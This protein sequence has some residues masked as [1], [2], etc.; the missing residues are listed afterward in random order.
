MI[1]DG[2]SIVDFTWGN[3]TIG[4]ES[5]LPQAGVVPAGQLH[6]SSGFTL[7]YGALLHRLVRF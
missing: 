4:H 5:A 2:A 7:I 1:A 3:G 6:A